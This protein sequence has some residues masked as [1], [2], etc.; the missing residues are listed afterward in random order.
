M[1]D[2]FN[3]PQLMDLLRG[4]ETRGIPYEIEH[5]RL[6]ADCD[7]I[8]VRICT[9]LQIWDVG[10]FAYDHI[11]VLKYVLSGE[12][13]GGVTVASILSELDALQNSR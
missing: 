12:V 4:L 11:E 7:G 6:S 9:I 1:E 2:A 10:F 3:S 8:Y 5:R 13:Q